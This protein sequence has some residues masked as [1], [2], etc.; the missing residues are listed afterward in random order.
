MWARYR[1]I[2][3]PILG[4]LAAIL[5]FAIS[6]PYEKSLAERVLD[7]SDPTSMYTYGTE[8]GAVNRLAT[9]ALLSSFLAFGFTYGRRPLW[10]VLITTV[11]AAIVG[12]VINFAT[13]TSSDLIGI[14]LGYKISILSNFVAIFAW[15]LLV[16]TG[17]SVTL[18]LVLGPTGQRAKR[19]LVASIIGFFA[20]FFAQSVGSVLGTIG[21]LTGGET[22]RLGSLLMQGMKPTL[23]MGLPTWRTQAIAIGITLAFV[24]AVADAFIRTGS[25]RL[26]LGRNE[27]LDWALD[28]TVMR[29]GSAE[30]NHIPIRG[31]TGVEPVHAQI[32]R[33]PDGFHIEAFAPLYLNGVEVQEALLSPGDQLNI[34]PSTLEFSSQKGR[35]RLPQQYAPIPIQT[36]VAVCHIVLIGEDGSTFHLPPGVY[37]VGRDASNEIAL[38]SQ[39][40]V[41]RHHATVNVGATTVDITDLNSTNG[42]YVNG[43][44]ITGAHAVVPND[45]VVFGHAKF[46][47]TVSS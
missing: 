45:E 44:P 3:L 13:D 2:I 4:A 1:I 27:Y 39:P 23:I 31:Q 40:S 46:R 21:G 34:G 15:C 17:F 10:R 36:Q 7:P 28:Y 35:R 14:T 22:H 30:G 12:A 16:P 6:A 32:V 33:K 8:W 43:H 20:A 42:T 26:I 18:F 25:I 29:I 9:G 38:A 11:F 5:A 37:Q 47:I 24:Y 19:A 41:S